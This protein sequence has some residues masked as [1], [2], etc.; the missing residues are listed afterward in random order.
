M[1]K[2]VEK[3]LNEQINKELHSAYLYLQMA[4]YLS[5]KGFNGMSTWM[6]MQVEE[7]L[8]HMN[9]IFDYVNTRGGLAKIQGF[10]IKQFTWKNA[11]DVFEGAYKHEQF[12]TKSINDLASIASKH[13]DYA[14]VEFLQW[15]IKEQVE[16][17]D[18]ASNNVAQLKIAKDNSVA[19]M[20]ID[21]ELGQRKPPTKG[22][23][24]E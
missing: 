10:S 11:L 21:R 13:K 3:A 6:K 15:F 19:I 2:I 8:I 1:N 23:T 17:E 14:S 16:E 12:I 24:A 4:S 7:E 9:K 18:T 22:E 20:M 5:S